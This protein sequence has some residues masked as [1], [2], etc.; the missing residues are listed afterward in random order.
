MG[1]GFSCFVFGI[2]RA[3][4]TEGYER[5]QKMQVIMSGRHKKVI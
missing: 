3:K 1:A 4:P 2:R 5:G